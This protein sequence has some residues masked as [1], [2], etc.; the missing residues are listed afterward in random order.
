MS[1][2][3]IT[4]TRTA[5]RDEVDPDAVIGYDRP[6]Q[7]FFLQAFASAEDDDL[8]LWIGTEYRAFETLSDL[9]HAVLQ[10]GFDFVPIASGVLHRLFEDHAR[11][12]IRPAAETIIQE[13]GHPPT[14]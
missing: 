8:E 14:R 1:R 4:V 7:T 11:E 5:S 2:Y 6:L 13:L 12:A 10:S 3:T 9:R